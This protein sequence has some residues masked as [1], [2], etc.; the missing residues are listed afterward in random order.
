MRRRRE[1]QSSAKEDLRKRLEAIKALEPTQIK[2]VLIEPAKLPEPTT[3]KKIGT[4]ELAE[5]QKELEQ[6]RDEWSWLSDA[7]KQ[8]ALE[9]E[10]KIFE[11]ETEAKEWAKGNTPLRFIAKYK[12]QIGVWSLISVIVGILAKFFGIF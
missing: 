6:Y 7:E 12:M 4:R 1:A 3:V 8:K 11:L 9:V 5:L 10:A 2:P